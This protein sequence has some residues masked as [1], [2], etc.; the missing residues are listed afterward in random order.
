MKYNMKDFRP[1]A[2]ALVLFTVIIRLPFTFFDI[3]L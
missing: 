1:Y 2:I 3:N